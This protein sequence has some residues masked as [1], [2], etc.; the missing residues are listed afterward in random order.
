MGAN[1]LLFAQFTDVA[2]LPSSSPRISSISTFVARIG[3]G[4][5]RRQRLTPP[6]GLFSAD[7]DADR[8]PILTPKHT[9]VIRMTKDAI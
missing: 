1:E 9:K 5:N 8:R 4:V 6:P 3:V 2:F 7:Y